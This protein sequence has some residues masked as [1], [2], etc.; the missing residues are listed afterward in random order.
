MHALVYTDTQKIEYREEKKRQSGK[1]EQLQH[2]NDMHAM[3]GLEI[4]R[5]RKNAVERLRVHTEK[6]AN[7]RKE[8]HSPLH[9]PLGIGHPE[10]FVLSK[11]DEVRKLN[12]RMK[13]HTGRG[14]FQH[15]VNNSQVLV[16]RAGQNH[17]LR[18]KTARP[19]K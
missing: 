5:V 18:R 17:S 8:D 6:N 3:I 9:I 7:E 15:N 4:Y 1:E 16:R 10:T 14:N 19:G 12:A 2:T 11:K 13:K